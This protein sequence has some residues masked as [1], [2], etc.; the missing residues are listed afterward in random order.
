MFAQLEVGGKQEGI[1]A[2]LVRIRN[3]DHSVCKGVRVEGL[4]FIV[5]F[6]KGLF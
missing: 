2:I 3:D 5:A 6:A 4:S 1:H